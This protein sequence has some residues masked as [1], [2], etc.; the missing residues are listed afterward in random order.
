MV[1][2]LING[3]SAGSGGTL[4]A[5]AAGASAGAA[6]GLIGAGMSAHGA[7]RL[8]S[9]QLADADMAGTGPQS[10]GGRAAWVG[11]AMAGNVARALVENIGDRISGRSAINGTRL[12]QA[13]AEMNK[14]A[15]ELRQQRERAAQRERDN[16]SVQL[17]SA[18]DNAPE[19]GDD[20]IR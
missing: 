17:P 4:I 20:N 15:T 3:S 1:Q 19:A 9:E 8:A 12:G 5:T 13:S 10:A 2:G 7:Y 11:G 18:N 6:A 16:P 14:S